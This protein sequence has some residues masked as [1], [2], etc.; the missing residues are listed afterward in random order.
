MNI[1]YVTIFVGIILWSAWGY[2][3]SNV[4]QAEYVVTK[5]ADGYEI[6]AYAPHIVAETTVT[7]N[8]EDA[9]NEGFRIIAG[10]IFGGNTGKQGVAMTAPVTAQASSENIA[11]TAP[12]TTHSENGSRTIAF[13][14]PKEYTLDTLPIPNDAR[15]QLV[16]IPERTMAVRTFSWY[17][18]AARVQKMEEQLLAALARDGVVVKGTPIFAGYNAPW[19][20]PWIVRNEVMVEIER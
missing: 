14:M 6:R 10:Y 1:F 15:V 12:V 3:S 4:E 16:P 2:F 19:T 8:Y 11:M 18:S 17:R 5:K 13:V 9:L 7:G 20:P